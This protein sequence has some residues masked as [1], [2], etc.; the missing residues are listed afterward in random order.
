MAKQYLALLKDKWDT[1]AAA[2]SRLNAT[3]AN[4]WLSYRR[5]HMIDELTRMRRRLAGTSADEEQE[6]ERFSI[7]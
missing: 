3:L 7:C 2:L 1:S 5:W 6:L 4:E